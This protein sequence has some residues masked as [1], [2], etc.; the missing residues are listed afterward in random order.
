MMIVILEIVTAIL[1]LA[2]V[3]MIV[4]LVVAQAMIMIFVEQVGKQQGTM[5]SADLFERKNSNCASVQVGGK[6]RIWYI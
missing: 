4:V 5:R 1:V 6:S 3:T 2:V